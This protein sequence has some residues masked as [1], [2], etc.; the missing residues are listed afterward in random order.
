VR[1]PSHANAYV[2][3]GGWNEWLRQHQP[4]GFG[5]GSLEAHAKEEAPSQRWIPNVQETLIATAN[6]IED[7]LVQLVDCR[8]E[9]E[10]VGSD[11][12]GN[13]RGGHIPGAR[14][15]DWRQFCD[16]SNPEYLKTPEEREALL[17]VCLLLCRAMHAC[18]WRLLVVF[19]L[20]CVSISVMLTVP[21]VVVCVAPMMLQM[22]SLM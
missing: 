5:S 6:D 7:P 10:F 19:V 21:V 20:L 9:A 12:R 13:K 2:P 11:L 16:R 1:L 14:H 8:T 17:A 22:Y 4:I 3:S 18:G 15:L